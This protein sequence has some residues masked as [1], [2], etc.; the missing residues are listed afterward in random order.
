MAQAASKDD[1]DAVGARRGVGRYIAKLTYSRSECVMMVCAYAD[2]VIVCAAQATWNNR[3]RK[4]LFFL[5]WYGLLGSKLDF[6]HHR[7]R[8]SLL[9]RWY[10]HEKKNEHTVEQQKK[11]FGMVQEDNYRKNCR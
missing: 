1:D 10:E 2:P 6:E 8:T 4:I 11:F 7:F 3:G 9:I 5:L